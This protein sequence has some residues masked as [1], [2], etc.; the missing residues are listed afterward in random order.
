MHLATVTLTLAPDAKQQYAG[1]PL[2]ALS[3]SNME[4]RDRC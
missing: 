2:A 3:D 1:S 4:S